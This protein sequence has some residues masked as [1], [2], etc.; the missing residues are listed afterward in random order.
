E[1]E[2]DAE[3]HKKE[4]LLEA[5]EKAH[6]LLVEAERQAQKERQQAAALEQTLGRRDAALA[7]RQSAAE[8]ADKELAARDRAV[9]ERE[10]QTAAAAA[11]Y[12][13]L[14]PHQQR[15]FERVAGLTAEEAK[16]LLLKQIEND[17]RRD[18]ANLLK[19]LD[20]EARETAVDRAKHYITQAIQ[21]C[22]AE[23]AIETTV[24][25]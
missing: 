13:Q 2:R 11:K 24:S 12:E 17:A 19:R 1:A 20:A 22:A 6:A 9:T 3:A 5:K 14:G 15:E 7:E 18:A 25:V 16:E 21:R 4:A 10:Q 8:R 23:H